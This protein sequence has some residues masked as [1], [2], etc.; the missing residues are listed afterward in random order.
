MGLVGLACP[1][2]AIASTQAERRPQSKERPA[3]PAS[4]LLPV[5]LSLS[6]G[7]AAAGRPGPPAFVDWLDDGRGLATIRRHG[8]HGERN[9]VVSILRTDPLHITS[10]PIWRSLPSMRRRIW[11]RLPTNSLPR[12]LRCRCSK[13]W[14]TRWPRSGRRKPKKT[15]WTTNPRRGIS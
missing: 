6:K 8:G 15:K 1:C 9:E 4:F 14:R 10:A 11:R 12:S 5:T 2:P 13:A 7:L 3:T